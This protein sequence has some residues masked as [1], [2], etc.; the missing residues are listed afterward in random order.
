MKASVSIW[1]SEE[2]GALGC[3]SFAFGLAS[4]PAP[5]SFVLG[6][7]E[8]KRKLS[9]CVTE[10]GRGRERG[11]HGSAPVVVFGNG[12]LLAQTCCCRK[13][14]VSGGQQINDTCVIFA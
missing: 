3:Y 7:E 10:T 4:I 13:S 8:R 11:R 12:I 9:E 14:L 2:D 5:L 1:I 6:A